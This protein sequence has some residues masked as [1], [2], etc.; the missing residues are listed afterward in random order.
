LEETNPKHGIGIQNVKR[1]L[2]L[3]FPHNFEL[4]TEII[5]QKYCVQL[6]LPIN[7]N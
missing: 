1:R 6:K 2:E 3:L 4:K 7:E 5:E